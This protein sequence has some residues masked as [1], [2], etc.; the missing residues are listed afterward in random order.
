MRIVA[1]S[2][3][4][5]LVRNLGIKWLIGRVFYALKRRF[6]WYEIVLPCTSWQVYKIPYCIKDSS[7]HSLDNYLKYRKKLKH[8]FFFKSED[9]KK[10]KSIF[11]QWDLSG[12]YSVEQADSIL[13]GQIRYFEHRWVR[14]GYPPKWFYNPIENLEVND[15]RHWSKIGDFGYGDIKVLWEPNRFGF[16]FP[17]VRAF[18]RTQDC[19]YAEAFWNAV[20]DWAKSNPPQSGIN[21]KCG[22]EVA[23]RLMALVFA[24]HAFIDCKETSAERVALLT[25]MVYVHARRI[26]SNMGYAISQFNN[27][28]ISEAVGLLTI[29]ILFPE[30]KYSKRWCAKGS[31][32]LVEQVKELVYQDGAFSQH[33]I[34][35]H[36]VLLHDL[37]WAIR[38]CQINNIDVPDI[39][40]DKT[41][42]AGKWLNQMIVGKNGEAPNYGSNDGALV[43][44]LSNCG[45]EDF[46]P[47]VQ[48]VARFDKNTKLPFEDGH[49]NEESHWFWGGAQ[50]EGD[51]PFPLVREKFL[52]KEGGYFRFSNKNSHL[53]LRC[54]PGFRHRLGQADILHVDLWWNGQNVAIDPGTYSYNQPPPWDNGLIK[55][56]VHNSVQV[57]GQDQAQRF[58]R[59]L[60]LPSPNG[61]VTRFLDNSREFVTYWEGEHDGYHRG[62]FPVTHR[63][64]MVRLP[65]DCWIIIDSVFPVP[66]HSWEVNWLFPDVSYRQVNTGKDMQQVILEMKDGPYYFFALNS[67]HRLK[68]DLIRADESSIRGWRSGYYGNKEP[69]VSV[70]LTPLKLESSIL[71]IFGPSELK[72]TLEHEHCTIQTNEYCA[73][74]QLSNV[75]TRYEALI[76]SIQLNCVRENK[77]IELDLNDIPVDKK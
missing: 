23:F 63:R 57:D 50:H 65:N 77:T 36:R 38:L 18:A 5:L 11:E 28:G 40:L 17:L 31:K 3:S 49:W 55:T 15:K 4:I 24:Y 60:L 56:S 27:H 53:F 44:P 37:I 35:Y 64:G 48:A 74:L 10:C 33:S 25:S 45:Y 42:L 34:N 73:N 51:S 16:V 75:S 39:L 12:S 21:W 43:F 22:Q 8:R 54:P 32:Y 26:D 70:K 13:D 1:N 6:G 68:L 20:E 29:G 62:K 46:R 71:S 69:A 61:R 58:G 7:L 66:R 2:K 76:K 67:A 52:A 9:F 72:I 47:V 59:F 41:L 19:R 30:L 14:T